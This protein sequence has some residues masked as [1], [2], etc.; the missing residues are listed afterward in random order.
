[1][2]ELAFGWVFFS[3]SCKTVSASLDH[4][5]D[6]MLKKAFSKGFT[7]F[8]MFELCVCSVHSRSKSNSTQKNER[9][10]KICCPADDGSLQV[11]VPISGS[12]RATF[13]SK[14]H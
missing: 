13:G 2:I 14:P 11:G 1:V 7:Y 6:G 3:D 12:E 5:F 8:N 4:A 10:G 9:H